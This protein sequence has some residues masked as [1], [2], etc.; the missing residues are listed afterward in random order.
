MGSCT[1]ARSE[2]RSFKLPTSS[3]C[4]QSSNGVERRGGCAPARRMGFRSYAARVC[5]LSDIIRI[6]RQCVREVGIELIKLLAPVGRRSFEAAESTPCL[7]PQTSPRPHASPSSRSPVSTPP[8]RSR[9]GSSRTAPRERIALR[10]NR[11]KPPV[12]IEESKL[13]H[14]PHT[15]ESCVTNQT[16]T[17]SRR[18]HFF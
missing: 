12:R 17:N 10:R 1:D 9:L 5:R 6:F 7:R 16:R 15:R 3:A 14:R 8:P 11:R 4:P 2:Q 18:S 13:P